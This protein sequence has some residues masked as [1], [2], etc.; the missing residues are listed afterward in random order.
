MPRNAAV[1]L[2]RDGTI[3]EDTVF[4][5]DPARLKAL[6]GTVEGMRRLQEAGYLLVIIT[7][8][9]GVARGLF[10]E[11]GLSAFHQQ[12]VRWFAEQGI[13][14]AAVYYCPH[15]PTGEVA[16]YAVDCD[17]RKPAPGMLLRAAKEHGID[18]ARSWMIG[19]RDAD[20]GVGRAAGCRTI[21]VH[22]SDQAEVQA[23]FEVEDVAQAAEIVLRNR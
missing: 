12:M 2:D 8:Q 17:C 3:I 11:A 22:R 14:I 18:L 19:D 15:Y 10:D 9:S 16:K 4:S 23:D 20:A 21:R 13:R 5:V 7:N 6:P 1:F